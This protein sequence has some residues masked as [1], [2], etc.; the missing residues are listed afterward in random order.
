MMTLLGMPL[1]SFF[2]VGFFFW[3]DAPELSEASPIGDDWQPSAAQEVGQ[4]TF[5]GCVGK[6][7]GNMQAILY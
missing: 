3:R 2:L 1:G 4:L 7:Y 5:F 6:P